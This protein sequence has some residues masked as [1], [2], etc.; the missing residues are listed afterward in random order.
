MFEMTAI[1]SLSRPHRYITHSQGR[2]ILTAIVGGTCCASL[3]DECMRRDIVDRP[4][5]LRSFAQRRVQCVRGGYTGANG[6]TVHEESFAI[7]LGGLETWDMGRL[8]DA[9]QDLMLASDEESCILTSADGTAQ[10]WEPRDPR[11]RLNAW[12]SLTWV[13]ADS[14]DGLEGWTWSPSGHLWTLR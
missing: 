11:P 4:E 8:L 7:D 13:R 1:L 2:R 3:Q 5:T 6:E 12:Q 10:F 9:L 14:T